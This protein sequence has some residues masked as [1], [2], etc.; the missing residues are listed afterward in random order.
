MCDGNPNAFSC[1]LTARVKFELYD[2]MTIFITIK[3]FCFRVIETLEARK[4]T[5]IWPRTVESAK[6][7]AIFKCPRHRRHRPEMVIEAIKR[8]ITVLEQQPR[9]RRCENGVLYWVLEPIF[10]EVTVG[11]TCANIDKRLDSITVTE[12]VLH[13]SNLS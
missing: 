8:N 12:S 10:V 13:L 1:V 6:F 5:F 11:Y 9:C 7:C 3:F 4:G 2:N